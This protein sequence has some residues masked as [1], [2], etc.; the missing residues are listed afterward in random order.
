MSGPEASPSYPPTLSLPGQ[1][2]FPMGYVEGLN[3]ART[4]LAD[5]FSILSGW[6]CAVEDKHVLLG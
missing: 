2:L 5:F 4:M 1:A 3:E 6:Q